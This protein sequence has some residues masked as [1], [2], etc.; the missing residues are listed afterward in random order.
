MNPEEND[1]F[2]IQE[3]FVGFK[4]LCWDMTGH[5]IAT[6]ILEGLR[7]LGPH[8]VNLCSEGYDAGGS[9][10]GAVIDACS[11]ILKQYPWPHWCRHSTYSTHFVQD[12][13]YHCIIT[14]PSCE[15]FLCI[16]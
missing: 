9:M 7:N 11:I 10:A 3:T 13:L 15:E 2:V 14:V 16:A 4:E 8:S 6:T 12:S 1:E 5:A